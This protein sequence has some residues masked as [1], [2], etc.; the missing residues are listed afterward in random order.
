MPDCALKLFP[1]ISAVAR[2][3]YLMFVLCPLAIGQQLSITEPSNGSLVAPGQTIAIQVATANGSS[4]SG[5]QIIG[6]GIGVTRVAS[7]PP[8]SFELAIPAD[9]IGPRTITALGIVSQEQGTFSPSIVVDSETSANLTLLTVSFSRIAFRYPGQQIPLNVVGTFNDG[10]DLDVTR[11]SRISYTSTDITVAAVDLNGVVTATG[12]GATTVLVTYENHSATIQV[13]IPSALP[14]DLNADGRIDQDDVNVI[15][16][17]LNT[18][19][20]GSFDA[21]DLNGD[22]VIDIQDA[23][24]LASR[25][26]TPGCTPFI[27]NIAPITVAALMPLPNPNGWNNSN[28]TINLSATDNPGG[29][30]VQEISYSATG[31]QPIATTNAPGNSAAA[32]ISTEG[33]TNFSFFAA[34][35]AANVETPHTLTIH[36]DKTPPSITGSR[37]PQANANGWNN[38]DVTASFACS[39]ALSGLAAG[40][41]PSS[42]LLSIEG[43]NQQVSGT[44]RDLADNSASATVRGINIDKTPPTI[45]PSSAPAANGNGWN[46]ANVT[47]SF[48]CADVLSGLAAGSPPTP[49]LVSTEG[50]NQQVSGAC[51]DL[52]GNSGSAT[53]SGINID[54]TPPAISGL[55]AANCTLWPPNHKFVTVATI[56]ATDALSGLFLFNVTGASNESMDPNDPDIIITGSG[57]QPRTVQLRAD[58]LGTGSDRIYTLTTTASDRAGNVQ[59]VTSTCTVPHDQAP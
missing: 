45:I 57:L 46:N 58:R 48:A 2:L 5:V 15:L 55:P 39:D 41:P 16:A 18:S 4:F 20:A 43:T 25:C 33:L 28:V 7:F 34:D 54:K 59:T 30:G 14:G 49:T 10:T 51:F 42:T 17:S 12:A 21:R 11:S 50:V 52:A 3:C 24:L 22:G 26:T 37:A 35:I 19:A 38:T 40:S 47:V 27:D 36:L 6:Q 32:L 9:V 23:K 31:A 29:S 8:Y 56:S 53:A 13:S 44:C 1:D